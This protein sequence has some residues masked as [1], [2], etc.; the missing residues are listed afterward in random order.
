MSYEDLG[1]ERTA[2]LRKW[3]L[4]A[5]ICCASLVCRLCQVCCCSRASLRAGICCASLVCRLCL[6]RLSHLREKCAT[7]SY[8]NL[9]KERTATLRKWTLR[10][11]VCC[12]SLVCRLCQVCCCSRASLC[13]GI[14]CAS[15][16]CR[17]C[18][19]AATAVH[20]RHLCTGVPDVLATC[21]KKCATMSYEGLGKECTGT[22][23]KWTLCAQKLRARVDP[24][25]P[26]GHCAK[27]LKERISAS[28]GRCWTAVAVQ[29][30]CFLRAFAKVPSS[31]VLCHLQVCCRGKTPLRL[32]RQRR[33]E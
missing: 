24:D 20:P 7:M 11:G 2:T 23:R 22:L 6:G 31:W 32:S 10:A 17:L 8:E 12:A 28:V 19:S 25:P 9:G 3:T 5:G 26:V 21:M 14:C 18:Q 33:L 16:V 29:T 13:A 4:R 15:L 1:K 30:P 27:F